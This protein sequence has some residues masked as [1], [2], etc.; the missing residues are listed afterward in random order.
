[1]F[2]ESDDGS[3]VVRFDIGWFSKKWWKAI[4]HFCNIAIESIM[5]ANESQCKWFS[6]NKFH[7]SLQTVD[8]N[9][10]PCNIYIKIYIDFFNYFLILKIFFFLKEKNLYAW[11]LKLTMLICALLDRILDLCATLHWYKWNISCSSWKIFSNFT[12]CELLVFFL[13]FFF[14]NNILFLLIKKNR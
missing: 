13:P 4:P 10:C 6:R 7:H 5:E 11:I 2:G 1:M 12:V 3:L 9:S 14:Y 8:I